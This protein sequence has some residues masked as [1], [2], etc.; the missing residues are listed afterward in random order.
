MCCPSISIGTGSNP[1]EFHS[2]TVYDLVP[3]T[4]LTE[5]AIGSSELLAQVTAYL[6][7]MHLTF[8]NGP[9]WPS[10]T[11][12]ALP[13]A[14]L[15]T[16][17][18]SGI[19]NV[20]LA[21]S[22]LTMQTSLGLSTSPT[23]QSS[24]LSTKLN[25]SQLSNLLSAL[26]PS[27]R[28]LTSS[29]IPASAPRDHYTTIT[30]LIASSK[31]ADLTTAESSKSVSHASPPR[32]S[33]T[34]L[35][36]ALPLLPSSINPTSPPPP[37]PSPS[38]PLPPRPPPETTIFSIG[39]K[40]HA[41]PDGGMYGGTGSSSWSSWAMFSVAGNSKNKPCK[42]KAEASG[43]IFVSNKPKY[44]M[45]ITANK[46]GKAQGCVFKKEKDA[47]IVECGDG[48]KA[49]K[50]ECKKDKGRDTCNAS[51]FWFGVSICTFTWE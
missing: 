12:M 11:V 4:S 28:L 43:P 24:G 14:I 39:Y 44:P 6:S 48:G 27:F 37:L 49:G 20:S 8:S 2:M 7:S 33:S 21:L 38:A 41:S 1:C 13:S 15:H 42:Q 46:G 50:S 40:T 32:Y 22:P 30:A 36:P 47:G 9:S 51:E 26:R 18:S 16:N 5:A 35:F 23:R 45:N 10:K 3:R 29:L 25:P 17:I 31:R 19:R 34:S